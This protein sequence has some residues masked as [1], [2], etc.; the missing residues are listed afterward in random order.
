MFNRTLIISSSGDIA[1]VLKARVT[2][3]NKACQ[4]LALDIVSRIASGMNKPFEKHVK[5]FSTAVASV[6][7]DQKANI[8]A[9]AVTTLSEMATA[10]EGI[11]PL[12]PGLASSL[13]TPNPLLRSSLT[14]WLAQWL[15]EHPAKNRLDLSA[16]V[17]HAV[18]C[19]DD[20][21]ADVR[22]GA[23]SLIP[24]VITSVGFDKVVAE[25][26]NLKPA[27][28]TAILPMLQ[29]LKPSASASEPRAPSPSVVPAVVT[30]E[31]AP[32]SK[33]SAVPGQPARTASRLNNI[34]GRKIAGPSTA[35]TRLRS[36]TQVEDIV[37]PLTKVPSASTVPHHAPSQSSD[38]P[39]CPFIGSNQEVKKTRLGKDNNRWVI[40]GSPVR[41]ELAEI[42]HGQMDGRVSPHLLNLLFSSDHNAI[43]DFIAGMGVIVDCY[44]NASTSSGR[45]VLG[46][47]KAILLAN[48]DLALKYAC[49]KI[50]E[51]Q[52]NLVGKCL[53]V[54]ESVV[55][56]LK[57][58]DHQ[59][60]DAE[61][62]CF[63][64]TLIHK[65]RI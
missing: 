13:E 47:T 7:A 26:N 50:H 6:L 51:P 23:Q 63:I 37:A 18:S 35:T 45:T 55:A 34:R 11:D 28:R 2:D 27:S 24:H 40:E 22:K 52:S 48:D 41:K 62:A 20:R 57:L 39:P 32:D 54:I 14:A 12:I 16:L 56:F 58:C 10:C 46:S 4:V 42:L 64:P 1:Q 60:I 33:A 9:A 53:D 65:V 21:N 19:L 25:T 44:N 43:N 31:P 17:G 36:E 29:N 38:M 49:I 59:L 5:H 3:T 61:A 8:R 15:T 30:A